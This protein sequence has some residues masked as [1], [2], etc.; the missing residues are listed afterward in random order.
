M[1]KTC[2]TTHDC[3]LG[4]LTGISQSGILRFAGITYGRAQRWHL[5]QPAEP[6]RGLRD[7]TR[8][9]PVCPQAPSRLDR[10][11]GQHPAG[12][13][14]DC[15][16]LNVWTPGLAGRRPVMV[17]LH[18]GAFVFGAGSQ[19]LYD[20]RLLAAQDVVVVTLNYRLGAFGFVALKAVS[21]GTLP[22]TGCEGLADQLLALDWVR[23]NI[24][25]FGGDP[26]NITL[27]G[28]SAGAMSIGA[29]LSAPSARGLFHKAILQSG[30]AHIGQDPTRAEQLGAAFL[31]ALN[32]TRGTAARAL[33]LPAHAIVAAQSQVQRNN[34]RRRHRLGT[35]PFQPV[36]DGTL[37]PL[38]PITAIRAG[39]AAGVALLSGTNRDEWK[40]FTGADPRLRLMRKEDFHGRV[41]RLAKDAT[42]DLLAAYEGPSAFEQFNAFMTD[43]VFAE[44][45]RRL[46]EAQARHAPC[47][48]YRC[49]WSSRFLGGA[50]GACHGIELGFL[51]G[52]YRAFLPGAF[53][54][55]GTA[56]DAL[57]A[58]LRTAW[59]RFAH[60]GEPGWPAYERDARQTMIFGNTPPHVVSRPQEERRLAFA[61]IA[62]HRLGP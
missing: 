16:H 26:D 56:A 9:G 25:D 34:R 55:Q 45:C 2:T 49:D 41:S 47:F 61:P 24:A 59:T 8:F 31:A 7:A 3:A 50:M 60:S 52:A 6:W 30:A 40:L 58:A 53:F 46:L 1:E 38:A 17:W 36:V 39:A 33:A 5:P 27:F 11:L 19:S 15:L 62:D 57:S 51:F 10:V 28:E 21:D 32:L 48:A 42:A 35:L 4:Q 14:E 54:G 22:A 12:Q 37:L 13:S 43:K 29:L 18:G 20:G 44:P 23:R